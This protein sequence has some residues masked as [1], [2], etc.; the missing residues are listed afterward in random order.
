MERAGLE[1]ARYPNREDY[2]S[3]SS[4]ILIQAD[5]GLGNRRAS[6]VRDLPG[7]LC[8]SSGHFCSIHGTEH[9]LPCKECQFLRTFDLDDN[10]TYESSFEDNDR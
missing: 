8:L 2:R 7:E 5:P 6:W 1:I 10:D 9:P 4:R 3:R